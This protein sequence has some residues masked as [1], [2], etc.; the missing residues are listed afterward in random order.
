MRPRITIRTL[1]VA[2]ALIA[3]GFGW[4]L[5]RYRLKRDF[6]NEMERMEN[7]MVLLMYENEMYRSL[8][9]PTDDQQSI[10][11]SDLPE[12]LDG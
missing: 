10:L 11:Q 6:S 5:D 8:Y 2:T 7:R 1:A 12:Q 9:E 4:G 3:L